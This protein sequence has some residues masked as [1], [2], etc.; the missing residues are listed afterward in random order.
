MQVLTTA[1]Y[2]DSIYFE[3]RK[4]IVF[5]INYLI[6]FEKSPLLLPGIVSI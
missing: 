1:H 2:F 4:L 5:S 3:V 6:N